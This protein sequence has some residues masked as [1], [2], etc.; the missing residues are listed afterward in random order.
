MELN[1]FVDTWLAGDFDMAVALHVPMGH[2][3]LYA[4]DDHVAPWMAVT[5]PPGWDEAGLDRLRR[6]FKDV[7]AQAMAAAD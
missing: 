4:Y 1:V 2:G 7:Q 5:Q 6:H 3:H